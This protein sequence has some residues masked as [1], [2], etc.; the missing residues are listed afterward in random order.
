MGKIDLVLLP[1]M[2][3]D[4]L[5]DRLWVP[6][7]YSCPRNEELIRGRWWNCVSTLVGIRRRL[8]FRIC[9]GHVSCFRKWKGLGVLSPQPGLQGWPGGTRQ[10]PNRLCPPQRKSLYTIPCKWYSFTQFVVCFLSYG[11]KTLPFT[12]SSFLSFFLANVDHEIYWLDLIYP[13]CIPSLSQNTHL[14]YLEWLLFYATDH[15]KLNISF[16]MCPQN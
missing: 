16:I 4:F 7:L 5:S 11:W 10:N 6:L 3:H 8:E 2:A 1:Y 12:N 13:K 15:L 14:S 9:P